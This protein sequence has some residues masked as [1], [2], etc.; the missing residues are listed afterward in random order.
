MRFQLHSK[1][2]LVNLYFLRKFYAFNPHYIKR[3]GVFLS[4]SAYTGGNME[5]I[6]LNYAEI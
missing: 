2:K 4:A 3:A 5:R 6:V 1:D